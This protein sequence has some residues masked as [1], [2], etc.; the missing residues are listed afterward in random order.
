MDP[1]AWTF[2]ILA[3]AVV[4]FVSGRVPLALV[5]LGV[6]LAL[7]ATGVLTLGAAFAG[8]GDPTV[9]FIA[10]LFVVSEALDA[11]G[12]TA[13]LGQQVVTRA[14]RG[15][16]RLTA[17]IGLLAAVLTAF[18]SINGAVAALLPV[19]VVVAV[20]AGIVPSKLLIPLA[21]AASA[22]SLLTLTGTPVNIVVSEAAAAAGGREFGF[23][24]FAL[25][26]IPL[27][28]LTVAVVALGGGRL[29]PERTAERLGEVAPDPREHAQALRASYDVDLDTG[30]LFSAREGVA[31]VLV[32]PR[33]RLIGRTVSA[34]MTTRGE[35]LVILAVRRGDDEGPN[36]SRGTGVAGA[37][38]LQAGDA[39]L[40][41]GPWAALTRYAQSPDVIAV[42][43]P[44]DLQRA[45]PLGRGAKRA[46][47]VL[48]AMVVLL[49]TG[50]V[51]AVVA[52][53][54][55]AG[56]LVLLRVLTVP[57]TYRAIS[58]TT[59]ILIA[60]M[61]PLSSAFITTGAADIVADAVL[62]VI[63]SG[64]PQLALLVLCVLTMVLG[65]FISNVATVLVV[66]PIAVAIAQTLGASVQP[67]MMAL[68]VAGAAAFLTP[69][70]T[71]ANLM[72]MQPGG[73]R[74]GDYGKLG[75]PLMAVYLLVAVVYVP[76]V[77]PF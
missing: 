53:L 43:P 2:L 42:T 11:T 24:E 45:V 17:I 65:Q 47:G 58:W 26:G 4:A 59:V 18:I 52:G 49:A 63:G 27:V 62:G 20:R 61:I 68:T 64:S 60:G 35:D 76:L 56:A 40:V 31:E 36:A 21:F 67:F 29:L 28:L 16:G 34:G 12:V 50:L 8:F 22:G 54:L 71:P 69:V 15:R 13:W 10:S 7:W 39:L 5:S 75:L 30:L 1:A 72:V 70:A 44:Q 19:V 14:G 41:Q 66:L 46:I 57:Q 77:W 55:A 48:G 73:Y 37:L 9:L 51:P 32:A 3:L 25:A 74:F 6:A 38:V 33:S 23:F